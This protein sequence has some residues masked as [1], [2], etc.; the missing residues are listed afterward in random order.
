MRLLIILTLLF[1]STFTL[2]SIPTSDFARH[3]QYRDAVI[4]PTGE[5]LAVSMITKDGD[6]ALAVLR[7]SDLTWMSNIRLRNKAVPYS[8]QW[9]NDE[10]ILIQRA[11]P[12]FGQ[13]AP[14]PNGAL[15]A[16]NYDGSKQ[17]HLVELQSFVS[18][19]YKYANHLRGFATPVHTL[20]EDN[21]NIIIHFQS[22]TRDKNDQKAELYKLNIYNGKV[23]RIAESP[24]EY[25]EFLLD[26]Q[27]KPTYAYGLDGFDTR[28]FHKYDDGKWTKISERKQD[29]QDWE[30]LTNIYGTDELIVQISQEGETDSVIR[31]NV[32]T[33]EQST[34]FQHKRVDPTKIIFDK[35][36]RRPIAV[37]T[38]DHYPEIKVL[39]AQHPVTKWYPALGKAFPEHAISITGATHDNTTLSLVVYSDTNPGTF[40]LFDTTTKKFRKVFD[41]AP[42]LDPKKLHKTLPFDFKNKRGVTVSGYYTEPTKGQAKL[43]LIV[44]PH[45]GPHARD[46]WGYDSYVQFLAT[47]GYAVLQVNFQGS[48][49]FGVDFLEAGKRKWAEIIQNDIIDATRWLITQGSVDEQ[50][51]CI[52]GGSFGG[53]SALMA[54]TMAPDLFKCAVGYVGVYDLELLANKGDIS[55]HRWGDELISE[56][57]GTDEELL[58][59]DSPINHIEKLKAPVL[60]VHGKKDKRAHISQFY[61]MKKALKKAGHSTEVLL[62][63]NEGHGFY[64]EKNREKLF[65]TLEKFFKKH[66]N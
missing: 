29:D 40:Y 17:K 13:S 49:G 58:R 19:G 54:P 36:N 37:R 60:L 48:D 9:V 5:Y 46:Y 34:V 33:G 14:I 31:Y 62:A 28:V 66:L 45:G 1:Y 64:S 42:W 15:F 44:F 27:G 32:A 21:S 41:S 22:W 18:T 65:K 43:P 24:A 23:R 39:D 51:I 53:Y 38:D 7:L 63:K 3:I 25:G 4:S 57:L 52:F 50:R 26:K 11:K 55:D 2:A 47:K 35:D 10:R 61:A 8:I 12:Y 6:S 59:K 56:L 30:P 20:P 16:M